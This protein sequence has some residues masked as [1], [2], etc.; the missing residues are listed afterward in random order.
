MTTKT[1]PAH[2]PLDKITR[3]TPTLFFLAVLGA[4]MAARY[5]RVAGTRRR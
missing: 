5:S 1:C 3:I 4:E 2:R